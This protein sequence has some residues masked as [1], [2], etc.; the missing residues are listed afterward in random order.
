MGL[1]P[2]V[3]MCLSV[4]LWNRID[5]IVLGLPFDFFWVILWLFLTPVCL[6]AAYRVEERH[7]KTR[8]DAAK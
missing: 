5:P 8:E 4:P 2:Y 7:R 1:V 6:A 3:A